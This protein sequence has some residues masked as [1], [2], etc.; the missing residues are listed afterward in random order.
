MGAYFG[1]GLFAF[2]SEL[3]QNNNREW[4]GA[5]KARYQHDV[6]APLKRF[7][8]DAGVALAS[9]SPSY[10]GG[11]PFRIYRDT[12]FSRNKLPYKTA[13]TAIFS[14]EAGERGVVPGFYFHL[15]PGRCIGGG[16]I[17]HAD[18]S[19]IAGVRDR[20]VAA[21]DEWAG[22]KERVDVQSSDSLKRPPPGYDA[23]HPH[24]EDLKRKD[25]IAMF[26]FTEDDACADDLVDRWVAGCRSVA[27]L[28]E[29]QTRALGLTW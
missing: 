20:I 29:F 6:E 28:I 8:A 10:A 3:A 26:D 18:P 23:A 17:Y 9:I 5:N 11:K 21:P 12:R 24:V 1:P 27:P 7:V 15:E 16:G 2:L 13:A 22:V 4:F 19:A 25:F 14:H